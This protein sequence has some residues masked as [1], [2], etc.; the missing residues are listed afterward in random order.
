MIGDYY[1]DFQE[2]NGPNVTGDPAISTGA[3]G[4]VDYDIQLVGDKVALMAL[5]GLSGS[6]LRVVKR[7]E[8]SRAR[9][10]RPGGLG[11]RPR[12]HIPVRIS[13]LTRVCPCTRYPTSSCRV[14]VA[15][16]SRPSR[17]RADG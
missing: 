10:H 17:L 1:W 6:E 12:K 9:Q 2:N 14:V 3:L 16:D 5:D 11:L 7:P 15:M 13:A 4:A 8:C